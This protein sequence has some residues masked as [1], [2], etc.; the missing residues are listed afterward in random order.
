MH[1]LLATL[2]EE[3][4][5]GVI[6]TVPLFGGIEGEVL[7]EVSRAE[8]LSNLRFDALEG[9]DDSNSSECRLA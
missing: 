7:V 1:S 9:A 4:P 2:L 5:G 3:V 6:V 8:A